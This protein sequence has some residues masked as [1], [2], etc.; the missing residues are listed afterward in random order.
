MICILWSSFKKKC[1]KSSARVWR[2][3]DGGRAGAKLSTG[4][5]RE[6]PQFSALSAPVCL[7]W[8]KS[9]REIQIFIYESQFSVEKSKF[10]S[11]FRIAYRKCE[12]QCK[13]NFHDSIGKF[14]QLLC[15]V[16]VIFLHL[17][18]THTLTTLFCLHFYPI[19]QK[20]G[21]RTVP[22]QRSWL[23]SNLATE[24]K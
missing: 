13:Q 1:L 5:F 17:F 12:N 20:Q 22:W 18:E 14:C 11:G 2:G 23:L 10:L 3:G 16:V 6:I 4:K 24:A 21:W 8:S 9:A 7:D 19:C 15:F